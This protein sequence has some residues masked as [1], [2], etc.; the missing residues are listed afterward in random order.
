VLIVVGPRNDLYTIET[1]VG[2]SEELMVTHRYL[3]PP[4]E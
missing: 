4:V 3:V 1:S 2:T